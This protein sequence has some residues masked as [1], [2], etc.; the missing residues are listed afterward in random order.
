MQIEGLISEA[1]LQRVLAEA[2][3][4]QVRYWVGCARCHS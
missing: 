2:D 1:A 3:G 4:P